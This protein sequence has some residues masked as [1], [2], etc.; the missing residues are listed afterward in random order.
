MNAISKNQLKSWADLFVKIYTSVVLLYQTLWQ[1]APVQVFLCETGLDA[2]SPMLAV[3][4]FVFLVFDFFLERTII[5]S[6]Y[7]VFLV[8]VIVITGISSLLYIDYGWVEN[9]KIIVF[10]LV[11]MFLLYSMY[12]RMDSNEIKTYLGRIFGIVSII[13]MTAVIISLYQFFAQI[14]YTV[15]LDGGAC[16]Q[17][18]QDGRLFGIFANVNHASL[19]I[20]FMGGGAIYCLFLLHKKWLK[21]V[22]GVQAVLSM[23]YVV[24]TG[25][26]ST[27]VC[28]ISVAALSAFV[29][30]R[31]LVYKNNIFKSN[32]KRVLCAIGVAVICAG[33][34]LGTYLGVHKLLAKIPVWIGTAD[35]QTNNGE[36]GDISEIPGR[37][38]THSGDISNNR[39]KIWANYIRCDF[40]NIK[41]ALFGYSPGN[42]MKIIKDNFPDIYI[43]QY[44]KEKFPDAYREGNIYATHNSYLVLL[45]GAGVIGFV[46][47][48]AFVVL[49]GLRVLKCFI[50]RKIISKYTTLLMAIL[51]AFLIFI[52]F[53]SVIF[54]SYTWISVIFWLI[55]GFMAKEMDI[56]E[57][58]TDMAADKDKGTE[59]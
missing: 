18:F 14:S 30:I 7:C 12:L 25:T 3:L 53:E 31:N 21:A 35:T 24:M 27:L 41:S 9:A 40:S 52:V 49:S 48:G 46:V 22:M 11:Q 5:Q 10:Q 39:F 13:F 58:N 8:A 38:D 50:K 47:M 20:C 23:L 37:F 19:L 2:I 54:Y 32:C 56:L 55:L 43:V 59:N 57:A 33:M 6:K 28:M 4:G 15:Q 26:R 16:R 36:P 42:Y 44:A 45:T 17:G 29:G 1:I 34:L 51:V